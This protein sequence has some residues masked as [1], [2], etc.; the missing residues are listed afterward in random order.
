MGD[1]ALFFL[2]GFA[3]LGG[4][5]AQ[6]AQP[7]FAR[8]M[9]WPVGVVA[10]L[11]F[12]AAGVAFGYN[13]LRSHA[14]HDSATVTEVGRLVSRRNTWSGRHQTLKFRNAQGESYSYELNEAEAT[15]T[16]WSPDDRAELTLEVGPL[17]TEV[18]AARHLP[19]QTTQQQTRPD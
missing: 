3:S 2:L 15:A 18:V 16:H 4:A 11:F 8:R 12:W 6:R 5:I 17:F 13:H 7:N 1:I 10:A 19:P 9:L 14:E